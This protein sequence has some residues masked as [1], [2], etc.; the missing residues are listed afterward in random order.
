M[1]TIQ[2]DGATIHFLGVVRGPLADGERVR[3]VVV[4]HRPKV[5]ALSIGREQLQALE[6][7]DGTPGV[8]ESEEEAVYM[9]GMERFTE[10]RKP[11]PC[12]VEALAAS[13]DVKARCLGVDLDDRAYSR[14]F[15]EHITTW[16]LMRQNS[17]VQNKLAAQKYV[18][19]T[20]QSFALELDAILTKRKGYRA[21]EMARSTHMAE[22]IRAAGKKYG[23]VL[24]V[25]EIERA[26]ST[27]EGLRQRAP[28]A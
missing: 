7:W 11:P 24:A 21:L 2:A 6:A 19:Q 20:P 1:E 10:I 23:T 15:T 22:A 25:V 17:F 9:A 3:E 4:E 26:A 27:L 28:K 8:A 16:E 14:A 13:K 5:V 12:F 18:S